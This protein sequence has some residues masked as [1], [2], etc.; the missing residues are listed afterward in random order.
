MVR[1]V[2]GSFTKVW[3]FLGT[4]QDMKAGFFCFGMKG[5]SASHV[6]GSRDLRG[7]SPSYGLVK[8]A[9]SFLYYT[10]WVLGT[11]EEP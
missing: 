6:E 8:T 2:V 1:G 11:Q 7:I 3:T 4:L 5:F 10:Q 9:F